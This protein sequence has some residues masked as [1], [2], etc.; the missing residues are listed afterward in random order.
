MKVFQVV[1]AVFMDET[2]DVNGRGGHIDL[3]WI[4]KVMMRLPSSD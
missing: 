3:H 2:V 1:F 4:E